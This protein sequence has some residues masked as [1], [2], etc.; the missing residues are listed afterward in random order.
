MGDLADMILTRHLS[1]MVFAVQSMYFAYK[2]CGW[3]LAWYKL[4]K[5]RRGANG[6]EDYN[7]GISLSGAVL[8]LSYIFVQTIEES[9][10]IRH[11]DVSS[12]TPPPCAFVP[13]LVDQHK[14]AFAAIIP[15]Y[16][17]WCGANNSSNE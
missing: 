15:C 1:E 8:A 6:K 4:G 7:L 9:I 16:R 3:T 10:H 13:Q 17:W 12:S 14:C 5:D 2:S 11:V